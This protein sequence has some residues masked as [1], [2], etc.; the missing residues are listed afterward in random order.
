[1]GRFVS[2]RTIIR[3]LPE[4]TIVFSGRSTIHVY[5]R[6]YPGR[7]YIF[8][9]W[10]GQLGTYT[11]HFQP[12]ARKLLRNSDLDMQKIRELAEYHGVFVSSTDRPLDLSK[13]P[14]E[15][16]YPKWRVIGRMEKL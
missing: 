11:E 12:F 5:P 8:H 15:I 14:V 10:F 3:E 4:V 1:M 16:R 2:E 6:N 7:A 9:N 13:K